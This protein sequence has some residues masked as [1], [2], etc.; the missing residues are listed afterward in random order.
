MTLINAI[1]SLVPDRQLL[2]PRTQRLPV[3][4][5]GTMTSSHRHSTIT[6]QELSLVVNVRAVSQ[7][8]QTLAIVELARR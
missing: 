7:L 8:W 1:P 5:D 3:G 4:V 6:A 2:T